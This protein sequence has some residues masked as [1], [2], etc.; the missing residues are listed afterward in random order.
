L[1]T[2]TSTR[3]T[4]CITLSRVRFLLLCKRRLCRQDDHDYDYDCCVGSACDS[5]YNDSRQKL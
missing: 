4:K 1:D 3:P 2:D 5:R